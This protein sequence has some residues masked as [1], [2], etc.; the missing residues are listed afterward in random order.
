MLTRWVIERDTVDWQVKL[1]LEARPFR[2]NVLGSREGRK[3]IQKVCE[4]KL[5]LYSGQPTD[6]RWFNAEDQ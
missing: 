1:G 3:Q 4:S 5:G 6:S 2:W